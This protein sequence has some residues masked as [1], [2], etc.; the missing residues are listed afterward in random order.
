MQEKK[1]RFGAL[2]IIL[3]FCL[4]TSTACVSPESVTYR[5]EGVRELNFK[6][7][8]VADEGLLAGVQGVASDGSEAEVTVDKSGA[9]FSKAGVYTIVL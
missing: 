7:G 9:D 2:S 5:I 8:E 6:V 1:V 4:F 3:A